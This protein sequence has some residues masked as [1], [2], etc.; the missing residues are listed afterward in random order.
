[1]VERGDLVLVFNFHPY[2]SYTDYKVRGQREP[3]AACGPRMWPRMC[4]RRL[5]RRLVAAARIGNDMN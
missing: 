4:C 3:R 5:R 1:M 2:N